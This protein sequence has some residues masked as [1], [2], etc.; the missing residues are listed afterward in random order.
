MPSKSPNEL[1]FMVS[2][3]SIVK[4]EE[5]YFFDPSDNMSEKSQQGHAFHLSIDLKD[6]ICMAEV[7]KFLNDIKD[8]EMLGYYEPFDSLAFAMQ[9]W[10]TIPE[11]KTLQPFLAWRPLEVCHT[12]ENTTQ[13]ARI[14]HNHV[15]QSHM[16]LWF[17]W[18]SRN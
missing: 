8:E 10:A 12:L 2:T 15:L 4:E 11:A 14:H 17:S 7:D 1:L 6:F 3:T 13:L 18:L 16:K 5:P 9:A